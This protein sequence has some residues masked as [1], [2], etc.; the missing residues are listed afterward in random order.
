VTVDAAARTTAAISALIMSTLP[1]QQST[2]K[3]M[4]AQ[5]QRLIIAFDLGHTLMDERRDGHIP[6]EARP[7]HLMPGVSDVIR[8]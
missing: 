1:C 8:R 6:I 5:A 3:S 2:A 7:I 4:L